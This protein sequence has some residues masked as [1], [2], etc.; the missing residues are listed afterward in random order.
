MG[1]YL[2]KYMDRDEATIIL[3][4]LKEKLKWRDWKIKEYEDGRIRFKI[5]R[6]TRDSE[7]Y[8]NNFDEFTDFLA[9]LSVAH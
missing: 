8:F 9:T 1:R 3:F 2:E 6:L 4:D 5:E 7:I